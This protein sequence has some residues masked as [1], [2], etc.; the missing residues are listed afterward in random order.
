MPQRYHQPLSQSTWTTGIGKP[1]CQLIYILN[2]GESFFHLK[3]HI[4]VWLCHFISITEHSHGKLSLVLLWSISFDRKSWEQTKRSSDIECKYNFILWV[5]GL[6]LVW[7]LDKVNIWLVQ[8][9]F[10]TKQNTKKI[11]MPCFVFR[12]LTSCCFFFSF[13]HIF[14]VLLCM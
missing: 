5:L 2:Y 12:Y 6:I 8:S 10:C 3:P 4:L 9:V 11:V 14:N 13:F 7:W 1:I